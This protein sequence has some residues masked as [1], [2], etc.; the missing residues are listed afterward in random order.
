[1]PHPTNSQVSPKSNPTSPQSKANS[2]LGT[3]SQASARNPQT[4]NN[5]STAIIPKPTLPIKIQVR[6]KHL[7][8]RTFLYKAQSQNS[9]FLGHSIK[10]FDSGQIHC[11]I[12]ENYLGNFKYGKFYSQGIKFSIKGQEPYYGFFY[13]ESTGAWANCILKTRKSCFGWEF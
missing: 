5:K 7:Q 3:N 12:P 10:Y 8:S 11:Q 6:I 9:E 1:M 2:S 13:R 4:P